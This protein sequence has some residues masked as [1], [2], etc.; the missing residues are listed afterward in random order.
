MKIDPLYTKIMSSCSIYSVVIVKVLIVTM[1]Q[2]FDGV[3]GVGSWVHHVV[4]TA[5]CRPCIGGR[6]YKRKYLPR[7]YNNLKKTFLD[8]RLYEVYGSTSWTLTTICFS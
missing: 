5:V 2:R 6:T 8:P 1:I 3:I 7:K 4:G